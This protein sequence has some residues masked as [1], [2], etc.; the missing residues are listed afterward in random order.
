MAGFWNSIDLQHLSTQVMDF[1]PRLAAAILVLIG[2][3][4]L[5]RLTRPPFSA[6]LR[7][8][9][10]HEKLVH[11]L[12]RNIYHYALVV[13][14]L[15]MALDQLGI[16]V[17][18]AL[19]GI[20]V[21]GVA[22]GFAAQDTLANIIAGFVIFWDKPFIVGDWIWVADQYGMVQDI[23]MRTTRIRT[24]QNTYVIL[25]NKTIIDTVLENRS[26]HGRMRVDVPVGIAYK[27]DVRQARNVLLEAVSEIPDILSDPP[28]TIVVDGLGNSSVDLIVRV[29]IDSAEREKPIHFRVVEAAKLSLDAAGIEIPFPHLQLFVDQIED[30]VWEGAARLLSRDQS[31][32]D[33]SG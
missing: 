33:N 32:E 18:A 20:G 9:G 14:G 3:L 6:A 19:A 1:L 15:V 28:P 21:A 27:E 12:I 31:A 7:R 16:N 22:V 24:R 23:T 10:L 4:I 11:I 30:P 13:V 25:P 8:A 29:W 26:Q 17:G 2:F 5:Y